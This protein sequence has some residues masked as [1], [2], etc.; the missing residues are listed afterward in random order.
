MNKLLIMFLFVTLLSL[1]NVYA[2]EFD[3]VKT[4][5]P[6]LKKITITNAFGLGD[7]LGEYTL[8]INTDQYL[9]TCYAEGTANIY[10]SSKL[11]DAVDFKG[12]LGSLKELDYKVFIE[13]KEDYMA[14]E[15]DKE[16]CKKETLR[17]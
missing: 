12:R 15:F 9:T 5:N 8:T 6:E 3:N 13:E 4:Y 14:T 1:A 16:E 17:K 10:T 11:F 7:T 2:F